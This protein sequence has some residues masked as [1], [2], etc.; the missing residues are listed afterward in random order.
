MEDREIFIRH[1]TGTLSSGEENELWQWLEAD[2]RHREEYLEWRKIWDMYLLHAPAGEPPVSFGRIIE[3]SRRREMHAAKTSVRRA[4]LHG[5]GWAA[6]VLLAVFTLTWY[7]HSSRGQAL[8][9]HTIE[10]PSGQRVKLLLA[11]GSAV[12]LNAQ[13]RLTYPALFGKSDRRVI[14]DGEGLFEVA[15]DARRPFTVQTG[16][17]DV[18]ALGT[19]FDVYAYNSSNTFETILVDGA[20]EIAPHD[21]AA[22]Y[23]MEPGQ[24]LFLDGASQ[25]MRAVPV[26]TD[27]Y[28]SWINGVYCFSNITFAEMARRL[29]H[30]YRT[31]II[32]GDSSVMNYHCTG[33]FRQN[34]SITDIMDVVKSDMPFDYAY[35]RDLNI[36]TIRGRVRGKNH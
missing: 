21:T 13:T 17:Y 36:L 2:S 5:A 15:P 29:E 30:Y 19:T 14:L 6:A 34:E 8:A 9:W 33:K 7:L 26:N 22:R 31:E 10:V 4:A 16:Q 12:W 11:D 20:V 18:T 28:T 24:R 23:R 1:F 25:K 3:R 35:D 32:I 27:D